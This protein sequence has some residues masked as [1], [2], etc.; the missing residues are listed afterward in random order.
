MELIIATHNRNKVEEFRRILSPLGIGACP[1]C[2]PDVEETGKTF[3]ENAFL[4]AD[5]ACRATGKPAVADDSG[6]SVDALGG[7]PGIFSARYAGENATDEERIAKL[8][9]ALQDVPAE[10]RTAR[11]VCA[12]CCVFPNGDT[13]TAQGECAGSIA[14]APQGGGGFGY[15]PVFRV[16]KTTFSELTGAEKDRISHRGKALRDFAEK[17]KQ[18]KG[19]LSC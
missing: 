9:R 6:L 15:D 14:F 13:V 8:L 5:S 19:D 7:A 18:Y 12:I 3:A 4:K 2:L 10:S 1:A 17:I 11:F 16:G